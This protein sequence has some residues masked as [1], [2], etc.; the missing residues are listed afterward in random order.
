MYVTFLKDAFE[1]LA[2]LGLKGKEDREMVRVLMECCG[3]LQTALTTYVHTYIH[4][5]IHTTGSRE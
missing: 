3:R 5:Y 4:K 2:R 1:R